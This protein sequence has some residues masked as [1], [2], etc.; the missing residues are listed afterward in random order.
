[1]RHRWELRVLIFG[2]MALLV[3]DLVY[4]TDPLGADDCLSG[5][6]EASCIKEGSQCYQF[7]RTTADNV[8]CYFACPC[9]GPVGGCVVN[10][11]PPTN[12]CAWP[13]PCCTKECTEANARAN[14]S[15]SLPTC[16]GDKGTAEHG[17]LASC[18]SK[19]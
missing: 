13:V 15:S 18:A 14:N 6:F 3:G 8:A 5:C 11:C 16:G 12:V 19:T 2:S 1:M 9:R 17:D 7:S 4:L 10:A